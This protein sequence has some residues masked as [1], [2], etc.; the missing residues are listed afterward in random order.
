MTRILFLVVCWASLFPA[1]AMD[2]MQAAG[3][4]WND[5]VAS[6]RRGDYPNAH[7]LFSAESRAALSYGEFVA[8]YG[9]LSSAREM[10][11]AKPES[12][13]TSLDGDWAEISYGGVNPGTGRKFSVGVSLVRNRGQW[14]LVAARNEAIERA[15][16]GARRL[17]GLLRDAR[18]SAPPKDLVAALNAAHAPNP[19]MRVYRVETDGRT[20]RTFPLQPGLRTFY[21]DNSGMVRALGR[22]AHAEPVP[23][24]RLP[25]PQRTAVP[26]PLPGDTPP[27][28]RRLE[29]GLSE[30]AE[31]PPRSTGPRL[32]EGLDGEISEPPPRQRDTPRAVRLPDSIH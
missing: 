4:V 29:N 22:T 15:E 10:V 18:D 28:A 9:P 23:A 25:V 5:F 2:D 19:V 30:M 27:P 32:P 26:P 31:P 24:E 16:A 21:L 1:F 3:A 14:G 8:E 17:L 13:S 11:V 6:I 12:L 7:S 20:F